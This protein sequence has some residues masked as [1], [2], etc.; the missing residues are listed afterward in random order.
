MLDASHLLA[1]SN[2]SLW[3]KVRRQGFKL[4]PS[5]DK[6]S[7][8]EQGVLA[9]L[10]RCMAC[11]VQEDLCCFPVQVTLW[12]RISSVTCFLYLL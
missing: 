6:E 9:S 10:E 4:R 8:D 11:S 2:D 7:G 1:I 5:L 12:F 3:Y